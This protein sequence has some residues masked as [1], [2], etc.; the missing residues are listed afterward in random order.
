[1]IVDRFVRSEHLSMKL[2]L[3]LG[4]LLIVAALH[5]LNR[6]LNGTPKY[7]VGVPSTGTPVGG[8]VRETFFV[9]FLPV[10]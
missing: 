1:M 6:W 2:R 5:V 3:V 4:A 10:T 9:G 8:E 7:M